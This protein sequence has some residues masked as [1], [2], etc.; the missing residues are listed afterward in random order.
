VSVPLDTANSGKTFKGR[1]YVNSL[2]FDL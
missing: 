1:T 2:R